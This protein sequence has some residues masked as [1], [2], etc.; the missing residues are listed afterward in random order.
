MTPRLSIFAALVLF[1]WTTPFTLILF[2][3][4]LMPLRKRRRRQ[5]LSLFTFPPFVFSYRG[6]TFPFPL[7]CRSCDARK[8]PST[9]SGSL[10]VHCKLFLFYKQQYQ[11][12]N[13]SKF[14]SALG[15]RRFFLF[16]TSHPTNV[17]PY[18][19]PEP[20]ATLILDLS[21]SST[22]HTLGPPLL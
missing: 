21:V 15:P 9:F 22:V 16:P 4:D 20:V 12:G 2:A 6:L 7:C 17:D 18:V 10:P 3:L 19:G 14:F 8:S 1:R 13:L 11:L 5:L